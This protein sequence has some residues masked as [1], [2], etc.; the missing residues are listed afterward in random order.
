MLQQIHLIAVRVLH[1]NLVGVHVALRVN[2]PGRPDVEH[3]LRV[4]GRVVHHDRHLQVVP[5]LDP[6][7]L[8]LV[9]VVNVHDVVDHELL[10]LLQIGRRLECG[11]LVIVSK[12]NV[13]T[14]LCSETRVRDSTRHD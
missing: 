4:V 14:C 9:V 3:L 10:C 8:A 2:R 6:N 1:V 12:R 7:N 11:G 5:Q 13:P